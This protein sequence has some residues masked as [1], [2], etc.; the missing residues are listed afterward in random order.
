[1]LLPQPLR[2]GT[3]LRRYKRFLA[4][5]ELDNGQTITAHCANPGAMTGLDMPGLGVWVSVSDNPKRKLEHSL[6]LVELP[7]GLVGINT[8]APN[9]IV[10][11]ALA[12]GAIAELDHYDNHR[13][14]VAY[15][16]KSRVDFVLSAKDVPDCYLEVKNVHLSRQ[17]GLAEFPD[18]KTDRGAR[19]LHELARMV[20]TGH[21]AVNLFLI[22]RTDC[23]QFALANDIDPT[24]AKALD[25]A[26][27]KG[28]EILVY[29]CQITTK[30]VTLSAPLPFVPTAR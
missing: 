10:A 2:H 24:Y 14:E 13:R 4:D 29:D 18:A 27:S 21:R 3:L 28:V 7:T 30:Q 8:A 26:V 1:M 16:T 9:R 22:Q 11:E 15:G 19:H 5:I 20:E 25:D 12:N 23:T 17:P 6:E